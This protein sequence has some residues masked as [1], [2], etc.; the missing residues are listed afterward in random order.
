MARILVMEDNPINLELMTY[1]LHAWG[2]ETLSAV[3]GASGIEMAMR[4]RP[5]L[6]VCDIEMPGIDGYE[7]ARR[8]KADPALAGVPVV[9][10]TAFA[11]VGD[12]DKALQAGFDA[13]FAKPIDPSR[14]VADLAR[15]LPGA[16][17]PPQPAPPAEPARAVAAAPID[18]ALRAP[19]PDL[20]ILV[21]DDTASN[22]EFKTSLLEPAGYRVSTA[23]RADE[24]LRSLRSRRFDLVISDVVMGGGGGFE[25]LAAVRGDP[26]LRDLPFLFLTSTAREPGWRE[27]AMAAGASGFVVRPVDP[28]RLLAEIR[29]CLARR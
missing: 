18:S 15:F 8:L 29:T 26:A 2:H 4:E 1:L 11:M 7:V 12:R 16:G 22:L 17:T 9:A 21:V 6:I 27:Q 3:D 14:F 5:D 24:A 25:L 20:A 10:V 28:Q 19:T 23:S 13:H